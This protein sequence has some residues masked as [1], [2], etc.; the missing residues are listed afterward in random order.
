MTIEVRDFF[1]EAGPVARRLEGFELREEQ[2]EM[3]AAGTAAFEGDGGKGRH[4]IVEAGTGVGKSFAY[5][6]PAIAQAALGKKVVISTHTI[7][8]QEQLME[9]DIP[10]LRAVSGLEF[11]AVLCKGRSNYLCQRRLEQTSRKAMS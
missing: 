5:L 3:A 6:V 8:L 7:S 11:S 9:K 10:F 1:S 4:L 2:R